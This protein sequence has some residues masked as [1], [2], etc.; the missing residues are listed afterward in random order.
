MKAKNHVHL[1]VDHYPYELFG[2]SFPALN[3]VIQ[4]R[5]IAIMLHHVKGPIVYAANQ[6]SIPLG[7]IYTPLI[8]S[9][10]SSSSSPPVITSASV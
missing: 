3:C 6:G 1:Y 4:I 5:V 8:S 10:S 2:K 7:S 9:T